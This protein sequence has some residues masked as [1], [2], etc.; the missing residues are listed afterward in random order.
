[1]AVAALVVYV[2]WSV[3]A[4]GVRAAIQLRRTGDSGFRGFSGQ[5]GSAEWF[6]GVMFVV[7]LIAGFAAP[8]AALAGFLP[9]IDALDAPLSRWSGLVVALAGVIGTLGAQLSMGDSWRVGVDASERTALVTTG[10]FGFSRNPI[11]AAMA[12]T[13]AGLTLMVPSVLALLGFVLLIVALQIQ[14]RVVEEPY[15]HQV[16]GAAYDS[17]TQRVARFLPGFG[18]A[19]RVVAS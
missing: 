11:F 6:A 16:H 15:L 7:A 13:A 5:L 1:M 8:I 9:P 10:A 2:V 17:Y 12:V 4:F 14:V 18:R 3:L 19:R